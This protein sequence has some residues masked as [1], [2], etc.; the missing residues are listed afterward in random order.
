MAEWQWDL[1]AKHDNLTEGPAWDGEGL[2]YTEIAADV[3]W[4]YDQKSRQRSVWR[5]A[6]N[7]ANG[8]YFDRRSEERRVGKECRL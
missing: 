7:G 2:L 4:R 5:R 6:T 3:V 1:I 8:L